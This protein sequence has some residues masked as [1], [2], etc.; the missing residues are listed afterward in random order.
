MPY[1]YNDLREFVEDLEKQGEL[2]EV[3]AEVDW[4]LEVGAVSRRLSEVGLGRRI[5]QG[6][7]PAALFNTIK[8]Y[9]GQRI[10]T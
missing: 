5:D 10:C 4:N 6:G 2:I 1:P 7:L 8:G 9:P 3:D